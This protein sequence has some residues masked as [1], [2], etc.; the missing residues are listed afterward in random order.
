MPYP[1]RNL[2]ELLFSMLNQQLETLIIPKDT[3]IKPLYHKNASSLSIFFGDREITDQSVRKF[4]VATGKSQINLSD[5]S[6]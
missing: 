3:T 6:S 5:N 1:Q 2:S 4:I